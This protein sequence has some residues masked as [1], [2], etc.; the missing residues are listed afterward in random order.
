M[1]F[2][3]APGHGSSQHEQKEGA[4]A[5]KKFLEARKALDE[6][7]KSMERWLEVF[8]R[9]TEFLDKVTE[10]NI[11]DLNSRMDSPYIIKDAAEDINTVPVGLRRIHGNLSSMRGHVRQS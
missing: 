3:D 6:S 2:N 5:F 7:I 8:K 4:E 9:D 11:L 10:E 1:G